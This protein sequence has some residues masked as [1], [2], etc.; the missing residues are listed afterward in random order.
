MSVI[1]LLIIGFVVYSLI[2]GVGDNARKWMKPEGFPR[3]EGRQTPR[4]GTFR[5]LLEEWTREAQGDRP[6][7]R[8]PARKPV[9]T[10]SDDRRYRS[11]ND[12]SYRSP[13]GTS[14]EGMQGDEGRPGVEGTPGTEG[15]PRY[16][17]VSGELAETAPRPKEAAP[18]VQVD[19]QALMQGVIWAEVLGKPRALKPFH[20]PRG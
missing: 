3:P 6:E 1:T 18:T 4:Q 7:R 16:A 12:R 14:T 10:V 13:E 19:N 20:G 11:R 5:E 2:N 9:P 8:E 15:S 17:S